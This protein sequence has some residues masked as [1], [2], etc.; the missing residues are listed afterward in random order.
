ME[1]SGLIGKYP[2]NRTLTEQERDHQLQQRRRLKLVPHYQLSVIKMN[3]M[4]L[5]TV[6]KWYGW[7][8][9]ATAI[10]SAILVSICATIGWLG[11]ELVLEGFGFLES[12][13]D[14][15]SALANGLGMLAV[16]A[17]LLIL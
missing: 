9:S 3:S 11:I 10:S 16:I 2:T 13:L 15:D 4:F 17:P 1:F 7:K 5:E 8:G 14:P 6:D 12:E